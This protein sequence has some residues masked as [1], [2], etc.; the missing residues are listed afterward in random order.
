MNPA[1]IILAIYALIV[2]INV[3]IFIHI[4]RKIEDITI[5]RVFLLIIGCIFMGYIILPMYLY[6]KIEHKI[7]LKKYPQKESRTNSNRFKIKGNSKYFARKY[8]TPNPEIDIED[9]DIN[10]WGTSWKDQGGNMA[11]MLYATRTKSEGIPLTGTTY[12]GKVQGMG[13]LVHESELEELQ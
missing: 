1:I 13:E 8:N 3:Y 5:N 12:Y 7:L 4:E 10:I 2:I 9:T 11:C 6:A